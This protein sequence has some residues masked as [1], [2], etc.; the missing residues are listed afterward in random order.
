MDDAFILDAKYETT[1]PKEVA[2][3]QHHSIAEQWSLLENALRNTSELFDGELGRYKGE[4]VHLDL[5]PGSQPVHAKAYSVPTKLEPAFLKE[6]DHLRQIR[7]IETAQTS[8]CA[9]PTFLFLRKTDAFAGSVI[10]ASS[11]NVCNAKFIRFR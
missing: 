5:I 11:A 10:F 9:S 1:S 7:V 2:D 6:L 3:A 8:L 4:K